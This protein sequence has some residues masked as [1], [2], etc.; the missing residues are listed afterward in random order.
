M[1]SVRPYLFRAFLDWMVDNQ[2]TPYIR[3]NA[4]MRNVEVPQQYVQHGVIVLNIAPE[5][6]E[7]FKILPNSIQFKARFSGVSHT[8]RVPMFAIEAIYAN[9]NGK[10]MVFHPEPGDA[11]EDA[12]LEAETMTSSTTSASATGA[13]KPPRKSHLSLVKDTEPHSPSR[14]S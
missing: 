6:V 3:V 8:I 7:G 11:V 12:E 9:E 13:K 2:L 4:T 1:K 10:G 14:D 5:A